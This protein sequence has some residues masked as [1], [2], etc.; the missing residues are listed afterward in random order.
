ME[1]IFFSTENSYLPFT[2]KGAEGRYFISYIDRDELPYKKFTFDIGDEIIQFDDRP[3]DDV[4]KEVEL[5]ECNNDGTLTGYSTDHTDQSFATEIT[6]CNRCN[7]YYPMPRGSVDIIVRSKHSLKDRKYQLMWHHNKEDI[8][9]STLFAYKNNATFYKPYRSTDP[10]KSIKMSFKMVPAFWR[11]LRK[12]SSNPHSIGAKKSFIPLLGDPIWESKKEQY[13]YSYLFSMPNGKKISYI[14]IPDYEGDESAIAEFEKLIQLFESS[15]DALVI[16]QVN[17]PGGD[18]LYLFSLLSTLTDKDLVM[19]KEQMVITQED[20]FEA[21]NTLQ[22]IDLMHDNSADDCINLKSF[23]QFIIDEWNEGHILSK[24]HH[25]L[26]IETIK[27]SYATYTK[28]IL[29]LT[30]ELDFSGGDFFPAILQDNKRAVILGTNTAGAGGCVKNIAYPSNILGIGSLSFT[31]SI[32]Q[33][34]NN[35][36]I[37]NIG[38]KPDIE[39]QLTVDDIQFGYKGYVKMILST[40]EKITSN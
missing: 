37:E 10:H 38:V 15:S 13:F 7:E 33:R 24:S 23:F 2:V 30:N 9:D 34:M 17:N 6:L 35:D 25:I 27:P 3:I 22:F 36:F 11:K 8:K 16:D 26:N 18:L 31:Y 4:V 5:I 40:L 19:P 14:R 28:P 1:F 20:V 12:E 21:I 29:V 32:A 39:Y